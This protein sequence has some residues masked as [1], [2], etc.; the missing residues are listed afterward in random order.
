VMVTTGTLGCFH[1][2]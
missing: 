2:G 1:A